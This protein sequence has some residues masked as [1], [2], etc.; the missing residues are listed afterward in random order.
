MEIKIV[1]L[2][3]E[4]TSALENYIREQLQRIERFIAKER[5]PRIV[6]FNIELNPIHQ[7]HK[8]TAR[9]KTPHYDCFAEHEGPDEY[10]E[11]N[12]VVDRLAKQLKTEKER[13]VDAHKRGCGK[14]C[15]SEIHEMIEE[16]E[17]SEE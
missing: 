15:R 10:M 17:Y 3:R 5:T 13:I 11:I 1:F 8:V 14:E 2:G 16:S 6:E 9:V 7:H 12:E 4:K